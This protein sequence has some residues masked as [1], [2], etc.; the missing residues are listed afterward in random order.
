MTAAVVRTKLFF[1]KI[2]SAYPVAE[3]IS[4]KNFLFKS[5]PEKFLKKELKLFARL[6]FIQSFVWCKCCVGTTNLFNLW[7]SFNKVH[8]IAPSSTFIKSKSS[9]P[10][11]LFSIAVGK[12]YMTW[13]CNDVSRLLFC[14][15]GVMFTCIFHQ[16][17]EI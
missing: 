12:P 6:W 7:S 8:S 11:F 9:L 16:I 13:K 10:L 14:N 3:L 4:E 15:Q 1:L 2:I 5:F 17:H